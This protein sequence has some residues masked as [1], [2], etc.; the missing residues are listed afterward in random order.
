MS[1]IFNSLSALTSGYTVFERD[2][3]LT[4]DQLNS[5][6]DYADDNIR[7]SRVKALGVGVA[8]GLR[9]FVSAANADVRVT[10]GAGIT[11]DGDLLYL[12]SLGVY[13]QFRI[14]DTTYPAYAPFYV[15]GNVNGAKQ[16][17]WELLPASVNDPS[18]R[19]VNTFQAVTG[20]PL[21]NLVAVLMSESWRRDNDLCNG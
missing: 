6:S 9:V 15:A 12:E 16:L 21:S 1:T 18:A 14:Y 13:T 3:V 5:L 19:P 2:Q 11:T 8:C 10:K 7:L 20:K 17:A 4:H